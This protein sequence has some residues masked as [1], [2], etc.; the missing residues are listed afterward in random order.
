M[1]RPFQVPQLG[2]SL[3]C[4]ALVGMTLPGPLACGAGDGTVATE[5][6]SLV[7]RGTGLFLGL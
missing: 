7:L 3:P 2:L 1:H 6:S 5:C 4:E